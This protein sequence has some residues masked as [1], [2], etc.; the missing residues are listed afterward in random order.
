M[1]PRRLLETWE[2]PR[3]Y[4]LA[5]VVATSYELDADFLEEDL[6]PTAFGL[7]LA[8]AR[9]REFRLELE[10]ALQDAEV[11]IFFH[12]GRYRPGLRR[13]PRIDLLALPEGPYPKLHAKIA[14]LRFVSPTVPGAE[15]QIVRLL[16]GSANL[17]GSGYRSNIEVGAS[18]EHAPGA[19]AATATAVLD[20]VDWLEDLIGEST[21][22]FSR[23]IRDIKAVLSTRPRRR[24]SKRI[25]FVGL[26]SEEGFPSLAEPGDRVDCLTI[27]SPFWPSGDDLSDVA[28]A[29]KRFCG[30]R[31]NTVRLIGPGYLVCGLRIRV[32]NRTALMLGRRPANGGCAVL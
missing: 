13:S 17:T 20:A 7:Q 14:F 25:R 31:W 18:I 28:A 4:R 29:L 10:H 22:Q 16:V 27:V 2:P 19:L 12:P 23:Q 26:P 15:N 21:A 3:G 1:N 32:T 30:G 5:S 6:L 9:G 8:P 11:S 24:R